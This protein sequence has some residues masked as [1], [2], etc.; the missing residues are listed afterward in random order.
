MSKSPQRQ[1]GSIRE[2]FYCREG[3][4]SAML[5][6]ESDRDRKNI[7]QRK[8]GK[9]IQ[10]GIKN[11]SIWLEEEVHFFNYKN[12]LFSRRKLTI[13]W[14]RY[15]LYIKGKVL[16]QFLV[17]HKVETSNSAHYWLGNVA[18]FPPRQSSPIAKLKKRQIPL[19]EQKEKRDILEGLC[20]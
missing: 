15:H 5:L 11:D 7:V 12:V 10:N 8:T 19:A 16:T 9:E 2:A 3:N 1:E 14:N 4:A 17:Y 18:V 20:F 6:Q 13:M